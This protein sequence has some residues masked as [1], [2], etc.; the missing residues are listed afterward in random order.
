MGFSVEKT[1]IISILT[2]L[3]GIFS[4]TAAP[5]V[6]DRV[7]LFLARRL[8]ASGWHVGIRSRLG[9]DWNHIWYAEGSGDWPNENRCSVTLTAVGRH[10]AGVYTYQGRS[11]YVY[12]S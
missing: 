10:V 6:A 4:R 11:W 12:G 7:Q 9:G 1:I 2:Y 5:L 8:A 3:L